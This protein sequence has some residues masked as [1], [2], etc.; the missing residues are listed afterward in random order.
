MNVFRYSRS[1]LRIKIDFKVH[2]RVCELFKMFVKW[3][4]VLTQLAQAAASV[5]LLH[6]ET[7][8]GGPRTL[9]I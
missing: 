4:P 3:S 6:G 2:N 5:Q 7:A 9:L 1:L 8:S